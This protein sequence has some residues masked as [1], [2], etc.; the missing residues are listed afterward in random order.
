[1]CILNVRMT[2]EYIV[3]IIVVIGFVFKVIMIVKSIR[4]VV[5]ML[6][7]LFNFYSVLMFWQKV[8]T[9]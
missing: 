9:V 3:K 7:V 2:K 8:P 4:K 1:M 5:N 6:L